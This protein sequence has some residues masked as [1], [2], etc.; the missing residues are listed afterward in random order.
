M[1]RAIIYC[2]YLSA[3][4][5]CLLRK[6]GFNEVLFVAREYIIGCSLTLDYFLNIDIV[7]TYQ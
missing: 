1:W 3:Q 4:V 6:L 7:I 2:Y 5:N